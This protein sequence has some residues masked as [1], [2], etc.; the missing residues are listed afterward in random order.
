MKRKLPL[1][2]LCLLFLGMALFY[3]AQLYRQWREYRVGEQVYKDL[4]QYAHPA[5]PTVPTALT[6]EETHS[7]GAALPEDTENTPHTLVDFEGLRRINPDVVAWI[8]IE[9]T[10]INYPVVQSPDNSRYLTLLFDGTRNDAGSI[11]MDYRNEST[12]SD[13]NTILYGH[14]MQNGTMFNQI[15]NYKDQEFYDRHPAGLL[16]TPEGSYKIEF[17]AG[18]VTDMNSEAWK[19]EF[20][21]DAEFSLWLTGAITQSTFTAVPDFE[22]GDRVVTLSTCNYEYSDAR[23]VLVGILKPN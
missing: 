4:T 20:A 11:F 17:V 21:S 14:N 16:V 9:G 6:P 22:P 8:C 19:L 18:Y 2:L 7:G 5:A 23:Y 10:N 3:G 13:R 15:T 12:L 1:I